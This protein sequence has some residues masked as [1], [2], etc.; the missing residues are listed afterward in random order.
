MTHI[1]DRKKEVLAA[2]VSDFINTAE[3]VGS[4]KITKNYLQ[5]VSPATVRNEMSELEDFGYIT[6]PHTSSG[7]I[8]TDIGYRYYVDNIMETRN[9]GGREIALIRGGFKKIG[10]GIGDI[11]RGVVKMIASLLDYATVLVSF[12]KKPVSYS[13]GLSNMF[14]HPEFKDIEYARHLVRAVEEEALIAKILEEYSKS[15]PIEIRIGHENRYR[16][17]KDFSLVVAP[18]NING[19][20]S[21][22][23]GIIGPT[24]MD[25]CKVKAIVRQVADE[26]KNI[27]DEEVFYDR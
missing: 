8:P 1:S 22:A 5:N 13:S 14:K 4:F 16:E 10:V 15:N 20:E 11:M 17:M 2:I 7:R 27:L 21:G 19:V 3:P 24:R 25:Y 9:V 12:G 26:L 18:Y 6:H 23:I